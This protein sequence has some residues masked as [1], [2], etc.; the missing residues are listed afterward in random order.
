[1]EA[2][3]TSDTE[4]TVPDKCY[5]EEEIDVE[6]KTYNIKAE[7]KKVS[8]TLYPTGNPIAVLLVSVLVLLGANIK[9]RY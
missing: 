3:L 9:R 8:K 1:M 7:S 5:E 4:I 6:K 2:N